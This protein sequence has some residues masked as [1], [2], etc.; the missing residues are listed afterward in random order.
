MFFCTNAKLN[1]YL[2]LYTHYNDIANR[3][4]DFMR[5][6]RIFK[7]ITYS[8]IRKR[9]FGARILLISDNKILLV[10]HTYQPGWYTVGGGVERGES[11]LQAIHREL[12]EEVGV[13]LKTEPKIFSV[14][15]SNLEKRDDYVVL[16]VANDYEE[17]SVNCREILAKE[18]FELNNLPQDTTAA[19]KRR[20]N[21]YLGNCLISETW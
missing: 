21:E 12:Q 10:K 17:R 20:I 14:Y 4:K 16:Y 2:I 1:Q 8:I 3:V 19:T 9:T 7:N 11:P 13:T 18:W 15:Y 6:Y 5:F